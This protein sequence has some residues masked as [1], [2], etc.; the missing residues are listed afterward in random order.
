MIA[1][2]VTRT[3][4]LF[5]FF[6]L[7][8][9]FFVILSLDTSV[10]L[11]PDETA[12]AASARAFAETGA[13]QLPEP[14]VRQFPWLHPRSFVSRGDGMVPVGFLGMPLIVGAVRKALG[15]WG[16]AV[17]TPL[18]A[19]SVAWPL[20]RFT[21]KFGMAGQAATV[22]AWLTFPTVVLYANRGLFPNLAAVCFAIWSAYLL[23]QGRTYG[24]V[25]G[26]GAF[27]GL[28][29]A[30][31]PVEAMW[32]VPWIVVAWMYRERP[33]GLRV[34]TTLIVFGASAFFVLAIAFLVAWRTYGSPFMVGYLLRDPSIAPAAQSGAVGAQTL[35]AWPFG[36][37]PRNVLYNIRTYLGG[38]LG[39]WTAVAILA[40]LLAIRRRAYRPVVLTGVWT[41]AALSAVYGQAIYQDHVGFNVASFGNSFLRY[42]LPLAPFAAVS[43]GALVA[44]VAERRKPALAAL[45]ALF[46]AGSLA[47][48]GTWTAFQRDDEGI[49]PA[50]GEL[51]RYRAIRETAVEYLDDETVVLSE[52]SDKI[53]FPAFRA[54]SPLPPASDI[55]G[56]LEQA[57]VNLALYGQTLDSDS[58]LDWR[59]GGIEL[60]PVFE[61]GRETLYLLRMADSDASP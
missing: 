33:H 54:V 47:S 21:R 51:V 27:L 34:R 35:F 15:D 58:V 55:R 18:L 48:L 41:L 3:M 61:A 28:A 10:F 24:R 36:F 31:R 57:S 60:L 52:R 32:L 39:P 38:F 26:S 9:L 1:F 7:A 19:L 42:L 12:T 46:L 20:W 5:L 30:V 14:L 22:T 29:L 43:A 23:M 2:R 56:L 40:S 11:S 49:L 50:A 4:L 44:F 6:A 16:M 45:F 59:K 37:H 25:M 17:F 53:F 13:M 8:S